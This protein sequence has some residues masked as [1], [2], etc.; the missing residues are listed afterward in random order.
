MLKAKPF[1]T[2][3]L[4][5]FFGVGACGFGLENLMGRSVDHVAWSGSKVTPAGGFA[6]F[7]AES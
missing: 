2:A 6:R 1:V 5:Q 7:L 3:S 4:K